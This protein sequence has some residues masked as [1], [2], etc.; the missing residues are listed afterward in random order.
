M[1]RIP[2]TLEAQ[3]CSCNAENRAAPVRCGPPVTQG[4]IVSTQGDSYV[5]SQRKSGLATLHKPREQTRLKWCYLPALR[6]AF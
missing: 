3:A 6:S 1:Q 5:S 2:S 4:A